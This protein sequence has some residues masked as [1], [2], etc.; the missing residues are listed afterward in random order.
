MREKYDW[1]NDNDGPVFLSWRQARDVLIG[2]GIT[3]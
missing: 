2:K 3:P 1:D